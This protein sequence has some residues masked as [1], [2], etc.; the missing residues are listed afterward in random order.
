VR[1]DEGLGWRVFAFGS[2]NA[3]LEEISRAEASDR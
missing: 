1:F 2:P 3:T